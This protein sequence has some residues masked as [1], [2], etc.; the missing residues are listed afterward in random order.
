MQ[1]VHAPTEIAG[2]MG[3]L[4]EGLR[5]KG[6]NVS[7]FNWFNSY[8]QYKG[9][10]INTDAYELYKLINVLDKF[11]DIIHFYNGN[12][13]FPGNIDLPH[14]R[15]SGKKLVMHHWGND[16]RSMNKVN[17]LN[18]YILPKNYMTDD[19]IHKSLAYISKYIQTSIVQDYEV[20][21]YVKD[22]YQNVHVLPLACKVKAMPVAYPDINKKVLKV[23]HAPTNR[24][25][26]GSAFVEAAINK[27]Q[28]NSN[29]IY[30]AIEK[31]SHNE[32]IKAYM[33]ADIVI[34]QLLCGSYGMLSVE[35]M[36]MGKPVIAF[37]REDVRKNFPQEL[38]IINAR[39]ET[40]YDVLLELIKNPT[41]L[42][43]I[44]KKSREYV[45]K[46]HD[47]EVVTEKLISIY[48]KL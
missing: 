41:P 45:L 27:L 11:S 28:Q 26:K 8:L 17:Q 33:E 36:A 10:I 46:H 39:P 48:Q 18:P 1:I 44:S 43:Q 15:Q 14:F 3:I 22:Y 30:Q 35:A 5:E 24:S 31:M 20:F 2:Q 6:Y 7:G 42:V 37:I 16:V 47:M 32:A 21:P 4:C 40:L 25:F 23:I 9:R 12:T 34:D 29:F 13:F 19:Q 38:P